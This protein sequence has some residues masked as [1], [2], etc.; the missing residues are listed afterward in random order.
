MITALG[1]ECIARGVLGLALDWASDTDSVA[2]AIQ[3]VLNLHMFRVRHQ[4]DADL[5]EFLSHACIRTS[6]SCHW[7]FQTSE[8]SAR[9][10]RKTY[11]LTSAERG[12]TGG[13]LS[14]QEFAFSPTICSARLCRLPRRLILPT[15]L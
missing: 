3:I 1:S 7:L 8:N 13:D 14:G 2:F 9:L 10:L 15:L 12:G 5:R 11:L 4:T 6:D